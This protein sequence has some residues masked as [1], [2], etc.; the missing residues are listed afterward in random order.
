MSQ[1]PKSI[2]HHKI[3]LIGT[4]AVGTTFA[5][6]S[7][8]LGV[9]QE[10]VI[11]D[12]A[13]DRAE[14]NALDLADALR[15]TDPKN[16]YAGDY[17]DATNADIV[18]ITAGAA[19]NPGESRID[20]ISRNLQITKSIVTQVMESGFN[21]IFLLASNPVDI[22]TYLTR[23]LSGFPAERVIGS[24]TS[25]DTSR[26][27][28][29]VAALLQVSP[30]SVNGYMLGEHGDSG[31]AAWSHL[32][33]GGKT[34]E[35]WMKADS[36]ITQDKLDDIQNQ[37]V[38]AA[39]EIIR[40]KGATYYGIGTALARLCKAI[41]NDEGAVLPVS[42]YINGQYDIK[43]IYIGTPAVLDRQGIRQVIEI[44]L[45]PREQALMTASAEKLHEIMRSS[46]PSIGLEH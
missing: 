10:L 17:K 13:Q 46:F 5:Y 33:V 1:F 29:H 28:K 45:N 43:D 14:G 38:N 30:H 41:L 44:P 12:V 35:E 4:G 20:L 37:V 39:Y 21:G 3:V 32:S 7:T 6:A 36:R 15:F 42:A 16:I 27:C 34:M 18:V 9:G 31:F 23:I 40:L 25:L 24:G 26:L 11:V 2:N 22:L 19:Q 8:L